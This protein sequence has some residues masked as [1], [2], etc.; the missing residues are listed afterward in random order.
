MDNWYV[1][2][3]AICGEPLPA[4]AR[5]CPECA[6]PVAQSAEPSEERKLATVLF[7]DLVGSTE[8]GGSQDPE[9][10][11]ATLTRFYDLMAAEIEEAGGTVEKFAGDAVMAAFGAPAAHEDHAERAL[12]A[13][14]SMQRRLEEMFGE[15]LALRIGVN[16]GEVV[17][18]RPREGSS[19]VTGDAV[20]V[21]ARLEQASEPGQIL[22]GERTAAAVGGAFDLDEP[23]TVQAKGKAEGIVARRL[24]RALS[25]ARPRG[26]GGLPPAFVGREAELEALQ[27]AFQRVAKDGRPHLV[28]IV[29]EAGVGKTRL[30][31]EFWAWLGSD[32]PGALRRAGRCAAYGHGVTY[33]PIGEI[34]REHFGLLESD[35]PET[36]RRRLGTREILGLTLGLEAPSDLHPLAARDRLHSACA[37][38]LEELATDHPAVVLIDDVHWAETAL[39]DLL[40]SVLRDVQGPLLLLTT[41]R[42]ELEATRQASPGRDASVTSIWL[43][44]LTS[45]DAEL[46]LETMIPGEPSA[47]L[48]EAIV[49]RAEGNPFFVEELVGTLIDQRVLLRED[50]H[51]AARDAAGD[52]V[53]PDTV[54][55]V[56]AAR[57]DRLPE[58]EKEALQA[59]S[60]IGRVFWSGP[61]YEL[62]EGLEPDLR[63][64]E[65]RDL[66]RRQSGSTIAGEREFAIKHALT[67][68][69]AYASL[70]KAK[71]ARLHARFA[72]WLERAGQG[73]AEHAALLAHHYAEAARP[74]DA[75][76]AWQ[77][78]GEEL[79]RLGSRAVTWLRRAAELAVGRYD[80]EEALSLLHRALA[81]EPS[82][83]RQ[84]ELWQ[85]IGRA[86]AL[87]FDGEAFSSAMQHAIELAD[88]PEISGHLFAELAFQTLIRA[89]MWRV[90]PDPALVGGWIERALELTQPESASR[91]KAL[92]ARCY[93]DDR[94]SPELASEAA[95]ITE[96]LDDTPLK[97][98]G[99]DLR[100][101]TAFAAGDYANALVWQ[102][103]RVDL[104]GEIDDP[105]HEADIYA[106]AIPTSIAH[107][108]FE[109]ARRYALAQLDVT[110]AL[111]PHHRLHGISVL[112]ELE[113]HLGN[114][115]AVRALQAELEQAV[116][117][118]VATP[119]VRNERSLLVCAL[120]NAYEGDEDEVRRLEEQAERHT[121]K[122]YGT[123]T[124]TPRLQLALH[125]GDLDQVAGL[126]GEPSVRRTNWFYL[127]SVAAHLDALAALGER[128]RLESDVE[129][130]AGGSVYLE[131][132]ALR[133]LALVRQDGD[134]LERAA[135][136]F[137]A[138][139]LEWHAAR[140]RAV[141]SP[142]R[143]PG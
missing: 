112:V 95:G 58:A 129:E 68:E 67:R 4:G 138:L 90:R 92:I 39:L 85:E 51:W 45:A 143:S 118:N 84:V 83:S 59:A 126:I 31:R 117:E 140:T 56:I 105:D 8:L 107:G 37:E 46:M 110:G 27:A 111:S 48:R 2:F 77:G 88:E 55:A 93:A 30:V 33:L 119:C 22:V 11:R 50:G 7:A 137:D 134:L 87:Y 16:T 66:I 64:L 71:R 99:F 57:I 15:S 133:A 76:L 114:W 25:L 113:E 141:A 96:R 74:E 136:G 21:A 80:I 52:L 132:F 34:V 13:A 109:E 60:V 35:P 98:Y 62:L 106:G 108:Q 43:D 120:A 6:S 78:D 115:P 49:G 81:L 97:S 32:W 121:M 36:V 102:R 26:L 103:K 70:P 12:H 79:A 17:V 63:L 29:G 73:R 139:G 53:V 142:S 23:A 24:V 123:V 20:N 9:R 1:A 42:P 47:R 101:L 75:D 91:A 82:V 100:G 28:N 40:D 44:P 131:P 18:G 41:A 124:G 19:F 128:A 125:R 38:F 5:F 10:T 3:C 54:H 122:G 130:L 65:E 69:V 86:N 72:D 94:K 14:L 127:A 135:R 104:V 61:I 116:E 89:G